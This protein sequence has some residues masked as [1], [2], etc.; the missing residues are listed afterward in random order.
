MTSVNIIGTNRALF[1]SLIKS[2]A[3]DMILAAL[4]IEENKHNT[5]NTNRPANTHEVIAPAL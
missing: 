3:A 1:L 4:L 2:A 5:N